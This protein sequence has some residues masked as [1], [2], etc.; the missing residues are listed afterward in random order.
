MRKRVLSLSIQTALVN[1]CD[2]AHTAEPASLN[3]GNPDYGGI[4]LV[5]YY[6][7]SSVPVLFR[8]A[9]NSGDL[10]DFREFMK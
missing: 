1:M 3:F 2:T 8:G 9:A 7:V 4:L 6:G 10:Y 5:P